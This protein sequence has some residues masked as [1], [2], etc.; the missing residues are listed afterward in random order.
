MWTVSV[1]SFFA[2]ADAAGGVTPRSPPTAVS[3]RGAGFVCG[4]RARRVSLLTWGDEPPSNTEVA[5]R[6]GKDREGPPCAACFL[7]TALGTVRPAPAGLPLGIPHT[8]VQPASPPR[9]AG[10][11]A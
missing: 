1:S 7:G 6:R 5:V 2:S 10:P 4:A 8:Q 9:E 11:A 3:D